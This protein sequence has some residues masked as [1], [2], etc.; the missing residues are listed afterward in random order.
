MKRKEL[1]L[2]QDREM[3]KPLGWE[4]TGSLYVDKSKLSIPGLSP[5]SCVGRNSG[6]CTQVESQNCPSLCNLFYHRGLFLKEH[7]CSALRG[8]FSFFPKDIWKDPPLWVLLSWL[9]YKDTPRKST[10]SDVPVE[11]ERKIYVR[12][13]ARNKPRKEDKMVLAKVRA[14]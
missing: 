12:K 5:P 1:P 14:S 8:L 13:T 2:N 3:A 10:S 6:F 11:K 9:Y 4:K 7:C